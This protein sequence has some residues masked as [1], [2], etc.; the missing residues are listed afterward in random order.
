M[1]K[2][3]YECEHHTHAVVTAKVS[4][5]GGADNEVQPTLPNPLRRKI[6][7]VRAN[8]TKAPICSSP[9][10]M[11]KKAVEIPILRYIVHKTMY[12]ITD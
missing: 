4:L 6:K 1:A 8:V 5:D 2:S 3:P 10:T 12:T 7:Q 11:N 9:P